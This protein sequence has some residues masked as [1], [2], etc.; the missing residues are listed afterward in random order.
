MAK[1]QT[2]VK[3]V[4]VFRNGAEVI[5]TGTVELKQGSQLLHVYG[6]SGTADQQTVRLF[7]KEGV[8]CSDLRF[9]ILK[10]EDR[11]E[12]REISKEIA[13]LQKQIESRQLQI[14]LWQNN[15]DSPA[16]RL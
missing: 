6:L 9:E 16:V 10:E 2:L 7:S 15:G 12:S 5:R 4:N 1:L 8:S 11:E 3:R 14:T 13:L